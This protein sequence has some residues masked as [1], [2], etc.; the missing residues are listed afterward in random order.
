MA[1]RILV[2]EDDH[3]LRHV[4]QRLLRVSGYQ[5]DAAP[6][7]GNALAMLAYRDYDVMITDLVLPDMHGLEL[8]RRVRERESDSQFGIIIVS[9]LSS[10]DER[11]AGL[12]AGA[13]D[14]VVKPFAMQELEA[15]IRALLRKPKDV[16]VV[17]GRA[18]QLAFKTGEPSICLNGT[19][20][21][22]TPSEFTLLELLADRPGQ[23]VSKSTIARRLSGR[24]GSLS[25]LAVQLRVYRL[26]RR[27]APY[28][29]KIK[30]LRGFGY[31][32]M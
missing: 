17:E 32:L 22:L 18:G 25:D 24:G 19:A 15:R 12:D 2:V 13:D 23:L 29:I 16:A 31:V 7:A 5:V 11:V 6:D 28:G 8:I 21:T 27:L 26:R 10:T 30:V 9:A 3:E 14:Y 4:L 1:K 20:M